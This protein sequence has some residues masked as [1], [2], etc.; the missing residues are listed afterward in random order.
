MIDVVAVTGTLL[1]AYT[2]QRAVEAVAEPVR[3]QREP[4]CPGAPRRLGNVR[5][6][7]AGRGHGEQ[8][9]ERQMV[10]IDRR[11]QPQGESDEQAFFGI[12]QQ[13]SMLADVHTGASHLKMRKAAGNKLSG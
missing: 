13:T 12:G 11:R 1:V 8:A 5:E 2:C 4:E 3:R 9:D 6:A 10:G 7:P